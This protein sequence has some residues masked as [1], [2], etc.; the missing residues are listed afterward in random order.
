MA[1]GKEMIEST[2]L[3][4]REHT[5]NKERRHMLTN[6]SHCSLVSICAVFVWEI[7]REKEEREIY[8]LG[9]LSH[10]SATDQIVTH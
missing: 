3:V 9:S 8:Y 6:L 10:I 7:L 5:E 4:V 1:N 2:P